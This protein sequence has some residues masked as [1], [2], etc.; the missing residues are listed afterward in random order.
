MA[1]PGCPCVKGTLVQNLVAEFSEFRASGKLDAQQIEATLSP[2]EIERIEG[3]ITISS[4]YPLDFYQRLLRLVASGARGDPRA[5]LAESGR[6][7]ARRV[8]ELGI[9]SQLAEHTRERWE[10]RVGRIMVSLAGSF[11]SFG[12]WHWQGLEKD[13]SFSIRVCEAG[14]VGEE[15]A[16]RMGG[17]IQELAAGAARGP[18]ELT[19]SRFDA[20]ETIEFRARRQES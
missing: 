11:F 10:N 17:F 9:Y 16:T 8:I 3:P 4:W 12:Q 1:D 20:G 14:P 19:H 7:S 6:S 5:Y 13:D 18:V 15:L 2:D